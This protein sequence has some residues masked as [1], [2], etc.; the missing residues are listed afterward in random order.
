M[1]NIKYILPLVI[2]AITLNACIDDY[3]DVKNVEAGV[4]VE[5]MYTRYSYVQGVVWETYSYLPN[6]LGE[7]WR[8]AASDIA[9]ATSE[10]SGAQMFNMGIWNALTNPD[11]VWSH[12][13]RGINQAN[14]FLKNKGK[15]DLEHIKTSA[16]ETDSTNYYRAVNNLKFMEGEVLFLK[17]F[18]YFEL[19]KR[20]GGVPIIDEALDYENE[21]SWNKLERNSLDECVAYIVGLCDDAAKIIPR[22]MSAYSW[23]EDG[24]ITHGAIKALK[25]RTLL[26]AA[27]PTWK[28]AGSTVS[29]ADAA[30][31]AHDVI[32]LNQYSLAPD[33]AS[34][35]GANN[36]T[37]AEIIFKRRYG[38][39]NWFE[40]SQFPVS[41]VGSNGNS[42]TPTQNFVDQFEVINTNGSS[43]DFNWSKTEHAANPYLNRDPRFEATI[44]YNGY[45]FK[46]TTI[47]TY[48]GGNNGLPRQNASKTGY[49]LS[50]WVNK[51][52]DLVNN[53]SANHTWSY[54][55]YAEV[56]LAYAE[57]MYNAY[58]ADNDPQNYGLTAIEAFNMVRERSQLSALQSAQLNQIRIERE[59]MVELAYEDHRF[60][61]VRRWNKGTDYFGSPVKRVEINTSGSGFDYEV[62]ELENRSYSEKMN[63]YPIPQ[64][65]IIKTNWEQNPGW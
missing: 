58:G 2:T 64:N 7:L 38:A 43:E 36:A 1:K 10:G 50:K 24:R 4:T 34:L 8:E 42:Y 20:Y 53:T 60:W 13:F 21:S 25:A 56:L 15:T 6:G 32:S 52:V 41:F 59:R 44:V 51:S 61:D 48:N 29:W 45:R 35:F 55:R 14:Q 33:Y 31:A 26:Y 40:Y 9:E 62:K 3:L 54:F 57:A 46:S 65:E 18:F 27:S 28:A 5:D 16:T 39:L 49:Y 19:V 22:N 37:S 23:Y 17:A 30:K 63:W 47:E 11:D 12:N